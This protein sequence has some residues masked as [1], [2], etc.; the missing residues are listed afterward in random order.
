MNKI[1]LC[2]N[3]CRD[4]ESK[5]YNDRKY[6]KNTIAVKRDYKN[7]E[8]SYDSDFFTFSIWGNQAE[9]LEKYAQKGDKILICGRLQNNNYEKDGET[10]YSNDIQVENIELLSFKKQTDNAETNDYIEHIRE[11]L[12]DDAAI[13]IMNDSSLLD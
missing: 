1:I 4:I 11:T 3:I 6:V 9:Y 2:G 5:Y 10:V 7:K 12:G 13:E 8:G